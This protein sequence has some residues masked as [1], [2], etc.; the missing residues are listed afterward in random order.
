MTSFTYGMPTIART[1]DALL[2][3]YDNFAPR[4]GARG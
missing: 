1:Y 4:L 3:G 2:S